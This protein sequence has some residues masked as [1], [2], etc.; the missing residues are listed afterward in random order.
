MKKQFFLF[1]ALL[2]F[3]F[4]YCNDNNLFYKNDLKEIKTNIVIVQKEYNNKVYDL[5]VTVGES[6][7]GKLSSLS[8]EVLGNDK[9]LEKALLAN[10]EK[11]NQNIKNIISNLNTVRTL[12]AGPVSTV[13]NCVSRCTATWHCYD[14]PTETG[15]A[16]CALDCALEC[17]GA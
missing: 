17:S 10:R 8:I 6:F 9:S 3:S 5:R 4:Y 13:G 7:L 12:A 15:T 2:A 1:I 14:K 11:I 16:L